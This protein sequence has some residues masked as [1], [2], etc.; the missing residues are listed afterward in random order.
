MNRL[1]CLSAMLGCTSWASAQVPDAVSEKD[2]L[3]DM[4]IVLSVSRLPQRLDE[5][6]GAVTILDRD[7]IRLSGARDVADLLRLV[8]GFQT[9]TSFETVAPLASYHGG[10]DAYSNRMQVLVDGRSVYSPFF[11]GSIGPGL[12]T[13]AMADIERI[14]VLRGSNSAAYGARAFL[15]VI[16]IVTR[17]TVDTLG[18]QVSVTGGENGVQDVQASLGWGQD[19]ASFRLGVDQRADAGLSGSN[20]HNRVDRVNFRADLRTSSNDEV[21]LRAGGFTINTGKGFLG[22]IDNPQRESVFESAYLQLDGRRSLGADEDLALHFS[23][24]EESYQDSFPYSLV[25]RG[26]NDSINIEGG[27]RS[28]NDT[29]SLQHT[30]RYGPA[31]RMVWGGEFRREQVTS[32]PLYNTDATF[33]T[34]FTRLFGNA[35]W[36]LARDWVLNAG[37]MGEHSSVSGDSLAPRLM[38]NWH[39][40]QGQ[41]WRAGISKAHRPPSTFEKYSNIIYR[42]NGIPLGNLIRASGNVEPETV[43]THEVGYLGEFPAQG[44]NLDVRVFQE[45]IGGFIRQQNA[46]SPRDYANSEDFLIKGAEYQLKWRPWRDAEFIFNQSYTEIGSDN[47]VTATASKWA[48]PMLSSTLTYFQKLPGGMDLSLMH[49]DSGTSSLQGSGLTNLLAMTRTDLRLGLPLRWG[50]NRGEIALVVQNLGAS[51]ADFHQ[52]FQFERRAF[53]TLRVEN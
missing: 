45:Q 17:H 25:P 52:D 9:S 21:Q 32:R 28:S 1:I 31:V 11:I 16:N 47:R 33:I 19:D 20:G 26:I 27:G 22:N 24:S 53:V 13:V 14:E 2:F 7:T 37:A 40:T 50:R 34:D 6:P 43:V 41:T 18:Q 4:P 12:Q 48:A 29:V 15:G 23:H 3:G 42:W 51:Y 10:F 36:R 38:L 44:V 46:T 8:P 35:E 39:A 30:F 5:T 49:Q